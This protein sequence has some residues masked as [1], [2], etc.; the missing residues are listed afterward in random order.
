MG[1][2][3]FLSNI[4]MYSYKFTLNFFKQKQ[5]STLYGQIS[6]IIT[7]IISLFFI[8]YF[9]VD[10]LNRKS[11]SINYSKQYYLKYQMTQL[12]SRNFFWLLES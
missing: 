9:A 1:N 10:F 8:I 6:S 4:D 12:R 7:I 11:P 3:S 2:N 5:I